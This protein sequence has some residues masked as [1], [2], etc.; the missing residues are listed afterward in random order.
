MLL[1]DG[2]QEVDDEMNLK[3]YCAEKN[4]FERKYVRNKPLFMFLFICVQ[5]LSAATY[6]LD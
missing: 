5:Q 4:I 2:C 6:G 3:T 1:L